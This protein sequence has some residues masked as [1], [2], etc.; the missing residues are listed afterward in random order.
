MLTSQPDSAKLGSCTL[1]VFIRIK[2]SVSG[3]TLQ[4]ALR[5]LW[6]KIKLSELL[7]DCMPRI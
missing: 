7:M 6:P 5:M 4:Q 1:K 3:A 2:I